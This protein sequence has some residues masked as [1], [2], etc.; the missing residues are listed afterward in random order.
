MKG[1]RR[2]VDRGIGL[3]DENDENDEPFRLHV[4]S[5]GNDG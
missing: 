4:H 2:R 3:Q 1:E 5:V